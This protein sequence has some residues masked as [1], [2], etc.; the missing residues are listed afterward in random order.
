MS[1][2]IEKSK[3]DNP[4]KL[5]LKIIMA[6]LKKGNII[7]SSSANLMEF[8]IQDLLDYSQIEAGKFRKNI[9]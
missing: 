9:K 2:E 1:N 5:K 7:Q 8:L 4:T 3:L 6:Q